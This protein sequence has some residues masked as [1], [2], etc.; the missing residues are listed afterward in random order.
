MQLQPS[1]TTQPPVL[2]RNSLHAEM[3]EFNERAQ[4]R[5]LVIFEGTKSK[6]DSDLKSVMSA[7]GWQVKNE[8]FILD[9]IFCIKIR[10]LCTV[11][12]NICEWRD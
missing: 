8:D 3:R 7:I 2:Q 4:R 5:N 6:S 10:L 1:Q 12:F 9:N 11:S